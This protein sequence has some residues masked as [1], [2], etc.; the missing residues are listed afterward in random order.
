MNKDVNYR[1][2]KVQEIDAQLKSRI[3]AESGANYSASSP[4]WLTSWIPRN[5]LDRDPFKWE[6]G[7]TMS[8]N[9]G[10]HHGKQLL[11]NKQPFD[12]IIP[13]ELHFPA[14]LRIDI[15]GINLSYRNFVTSGSL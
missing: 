14:N 11:L 1:R 13:S 12:E 3:H 8:R 4:D 7:Q 5:I 6:P 2:T 9:R 10:I 15:R